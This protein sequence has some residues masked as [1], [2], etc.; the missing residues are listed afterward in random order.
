MKKF[1]YF[2]AIVFTIFFSSIELNAFTTFNVTILNLERVDVAIPF[3]SNGTNTLYSLENANL[4]FD[5]LEIT[6]ANSTSLIQN[7][8]NI[9]YSICLALVLINLVA[10]IKIIVQMIDL[11]FLFRKKDK[12]VALKL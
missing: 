4:Q 2:L 3:L 12:V 11:F 1:N 5:K 10:Q 6:A 7:N 8:L 9:L